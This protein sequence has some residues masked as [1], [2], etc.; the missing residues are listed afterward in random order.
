MPVYCR[1]VLTVALSWSRCR[2][3]LQ[4]G[5]RKR[6]PRIVVW[7][8]KLSARRPPYRGSSAESTSCVRMMTCQRSTYPVL[9]YSVRGCS[10][11]VDL[12][13]G[14][15]DHGTL[16][17]V[18][19]ISQAAPSGSHRRR[20]RADAGGSGAQTATILRL[21]V[22]VRRTPRRCGRAR[23]VCKAVPQ[24]LLLLLTP[25]A[26]GRTTLRANHRLSAFVRG[27]LGPFWGLRCRC[28]D[29]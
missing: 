20:P 18:S 22:R 15:D 27:P 9:G 2:R 8:W 10:L 11:I 26:F 21:E 19:T 7:N 24:A 3:T 1:V 12:F 6:S 17:A 16:P 28:W 13:A 4:E 29:I 25:V 5:L 14:L 23:A